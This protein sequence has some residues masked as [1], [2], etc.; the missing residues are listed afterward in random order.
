MM[1][2][3]PASRRVVSFAYTFL[4][5]ASDTQNNI[6]NGLPS[7]TSILVAAVRAFGS[8][9]PDENVRNP[10]SVAD[11]LIGPSELAFISDHPG[12]TGLM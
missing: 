10:D 8:R 4:M 5:I 3:E 1:S 6:E 9:E 11:L 2:S 12:S 7:R